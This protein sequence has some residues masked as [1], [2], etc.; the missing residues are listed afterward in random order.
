VGFAISK[1]VNSV[2]QRKLGTG[3]IEL[4]RSTKSKDQIWKE[5]SQ[6]LLQLVGDWHSD[7]SRQA[8][9]AVN[10]PLMGLTSQ[11]PG[12]KTKEAIGEKS[13]LIVAA[14]EKDIGCRI[15]NPICCLKIRPEI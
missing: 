3:I 1:A 10:S 14:R 7:V 5:V 11:S 2:S 8:L 13:G 15:D 9:H 6:P 12:G 4:G